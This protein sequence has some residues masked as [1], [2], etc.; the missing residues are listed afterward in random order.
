[1]RASAST[2]ERSARIRP[3]GSGLK[4]IAA[5]TSASPPPATAMRLRSE[6]RSGSGTTRIL[7]AAKHRLAHLVRVRHDSRRER[8]AIF[9]SSR[10][11]TQFTSGD[12]LDEPSLISESA[13]RERR[14]T[15]LVGG[16]DRVGL[17]RGIGNDAA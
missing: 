8:R 6:E 12:R 7:G 14:A 1:M 13:R 10:G 5:G 3:S 16:V 2:S 15:I 11:G 4:P 9:R 17:E